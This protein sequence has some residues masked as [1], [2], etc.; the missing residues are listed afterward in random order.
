MAAYTDVNARKTMYKR[1][2]APADGFL[3]IVPITGCYFHNY[4]LYI[5]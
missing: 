3:K 5:I 1:V 2:E 4:D